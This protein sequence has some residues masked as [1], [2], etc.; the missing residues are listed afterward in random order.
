MA[1][2]EEKPAIKKEAPY[3]PVKYFVSSLN[4]FF[5]HHLVP[6]LRNDATH[7]DNP[8]RIIGTC[9]ASRPNKIPQGIRKVID[10]LPA[11]SDAEGQLL[12]RSAAQLRRH[13][14]RPQRLRPQGG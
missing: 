5:A 3:V 14:L 12:R 8:N 2:S 13:H 11:H 1:E 9:L 7:P 6:R 10:V 4:T